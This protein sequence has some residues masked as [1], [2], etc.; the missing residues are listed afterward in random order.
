[1]RM[2]GYVKVRIAYVG[3]LRRLVGEST[4]EIE[5]GSHTLSGLIDELTRRYGDG[6]RESL[7]DP[8]TNRLR[9]YVNVS[10]NGKNA[11]HFE[12]LNTELR[13]GDRVTF[14]L[15]VAGG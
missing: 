2:V 3:F 9:P 8:E 6:F 7:L 11:Q 1:M 15:A 4:E 5:L 12:G 13:N 14:L 10:V